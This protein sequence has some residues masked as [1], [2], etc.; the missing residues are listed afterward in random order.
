MSDSARLFAE[1]GFIVVPRLLD[2][3]EVPGIK[4]EIGRILSAAGPGVAETGVFVGLA[5]S[6]AALRALAADA[7]ILDVLEPLIGPDIE[8]L[9]DK[10]V[11][12]SAATAYGSPWHQDWP[13]WKGAHKLS[14]WIAL[15][16][17]TPE[18]GCLKLLP[19][20][21]RTVAEHT[22]AIAAGAVPAFV[23]RLDEDAV[24]ESQAVTAPLEPGGAVVFHDLL[25]HASHPNRSGADRWAL[26]ST[27]RS[28]A[29][30]DLDY[31]WSVAAAVVRGERRAP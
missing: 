18:N 5:A 20:S 26:I 14:V 17:A 4:E 19:A 8:F 31:E 1:Q 10:V 25:L 23:H 21:H 7:R 11:Y 27:Y 9:S 16:R 13:Y 3:G 28:A 15:D 30:A 6:S 24:D 2:A 12:K 29:E 22:G